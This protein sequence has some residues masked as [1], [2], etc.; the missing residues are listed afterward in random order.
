MIKFVSPSDWD[1]DCS[2]VALVK[3]GSDGKLHYHDRQEFIK[4]ASGSENIFLPY[5]ESVKFA[6]DEVPV[7]MIALGALESYGPNRNGDGFR[8]TALKKYHK[9]F[10]KYAKLYRNHKN[11]DPNESYGVVKLAVYNDKMKRVELLVGLNATKSAAERNKGHIADRELEK[12]ARGEDFGVSMACRVPYDECSICG[13]IARSRDEYCT[14]EKCAGGGCKTNLGKLVKIGNDIKQV[15]VYNDHPSFFDISHV[16]RPADRIA[17]AT[18]ADWLEEDKNLNNIKSSSYHLFSEKI[19]AIRE[20]EEVEDITPPLHVVNKNDKNLVK[21]ASLV[22]PIKLLELEKWTGNSKIP[23]YFTDHIKIAHALADIENDKRFEP[24]PLVKIGFDTRLKTDLNVSHFCD[25]ENIEK[26]A[27]FLAALA[28]EKIILNLRE[29][30]NMINKSHLYKKAQENLK[31][32]YKRLIDSDQLEKE[33]IDNPFHLSYLTVI[34]NEKMKKIAKILAPAHSL[35][36]KW[37]EER[38]K[39]GSIRGYHLEDINKNKKEMLKNNK[40]SIDDETNKCL[41][42][43]ACYQIAAICRVAKQD[44]QAANIY[45]IARLAVYQNY[46]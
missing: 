19:A 31:N 15:F 18:K 16:F 1:F 10:E 24:H 26:T 14:M 21:K 7:H 20:K 33:I 39:L 46:V 43:F 29:F 44:R 3:I 12:I 40:L 42:K 37:L 17:W 4:R 13:N 22:V 32:V 34:P 28:D 25:T 23:V 36:N 6:K 35:D 9:T 41:N 2:T 11:K 30:L 38:V 27:A 5:L 8:E 45:D